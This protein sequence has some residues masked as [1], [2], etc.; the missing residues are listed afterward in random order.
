MCNKSA[1]EPRAPDKCKDDTKGEWAVELDLRQQRL[2]E[3]NLRLVYFVL[4]KMGI[5]RVRGDYDDLFGAGCV[6]LCNAARA[7][8]EGGSPFSTYA[9]HVIRH[10]VLGELARTSREERHAALGE[11][12]ER[13][14]APESGFEAV[15]A[16]MELEAFCRQADRYLG[17]T[18]AA[19]LRLFASGKDCRMIAEKLGLS[20]SAVEKAKKK[21]VE[22]LKS[23]LVGGDC[24]WRR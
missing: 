2:C 22:A 20:A 21:G 16:A 12:D 4:K 5:S 10:E 6:G 7:W 9:F 3:E 14:P 17:G 23:W 15:E 8:H 18:S 24:G 1:A 19:V 11:F 13:L